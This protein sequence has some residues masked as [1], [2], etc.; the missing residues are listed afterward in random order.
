MHEHEQDAQGRQI[1]TTSGEAPSVVRAQ[2][3]QEGHTGQHSW[4]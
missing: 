1:C 3:Q 2:Q 4:T